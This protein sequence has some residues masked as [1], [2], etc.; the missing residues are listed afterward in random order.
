ME[1]NVEL[2]VERI[3][4]RTAR[5]AAEVLPDSG[6]GYAIGFVYAPSK[7]YFIA[8]RGR[9]WE[10]PDG[11]D[12]GFD[13]CFEL[14]VFNRDTEVRWVSDGPGSGV[15][16]V[17]SDG[18]VLDAEILGDGAVRRPKRLDPPDGA[19]RPSGALLWGAV[20]SSSAPGWVT[21]T[22]SR[23][24]SLT[25]PCEG[26]CAEGERLRFV[27]VEYVGEDE[28]GNSSVSDVRYV[29]IEIAGTAG[30]GDANEEE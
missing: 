14:R 15:V 6:D 9:G 22:E 27:E 5:Q 2:R 13:D 25:V 3:E 28:Y 18:E 16:W 10:G 4:G 12:P 11:C 21:L 29:G 20:S 8:R 1:R 30:A 23:V 19:G 26:N 7:A 17:V 24:G